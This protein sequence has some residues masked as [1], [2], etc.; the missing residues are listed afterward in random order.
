ML[1]VDNDFHRII[2]R[3]CRKER[4]WL[5]I[6]K[7]DYNYDRLRV[8]VVPQSLDGIIRALPDQGDR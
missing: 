4:S 2:F 7:L 5:Y 6:K 1:A 3:A 8:M